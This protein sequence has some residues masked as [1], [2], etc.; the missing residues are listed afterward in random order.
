MITKFSRVEKFGGELNLP[1]DKSISHRSVMFSSLAKGKSRIVNY[2]DSEDINSTISIFRTLGVDIRKSPEEIIIEGLG[3]KGLKKSSTNLDAGNSGTTSRLVCGILCAQ[4]FDST[5]IGDESLSKRPMNR[6]MD[7]LG[8]FG[9]KFS[10]NNGY[11]PLT[12]H[13]VEN[14]TPVNYELK[15]ASAQV[16]SAMLLAGMHLKEKSCIIEKEI[17]RDHTERMLGMPFEIKDGKKYIYTSLDYYPEA[18]E[19]YVPSDISTAAFFIVLGMCKKDSDIILKNVSLNETRAG[20]VDVASKM[21]G[22]IEV[23]ERKEIGS[24][25]FGD[26]RIRF[27]DLKNIKIP[28]EIIPNIIDEIPVLS[29]A[30]YFAE[31]KF[32]IRNAEELRVKECDR[33]KAMVENYKL[34]GLEVEEFADGF[35]I[36]G[37]IKNKEVVFDSYGD[38]RIAMAFAVMI[39]LTGIDSGVKDFDCV[40][41]SNPGFLQQVAKITR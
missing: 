12:V 22:R 28:K 41:I 4:D 39:L 1:G 24:E 18:R 20:I 25:P 17:T 21:N 14:L 9:A 34:L 31:G 30:G 29:V 5:L 6:V 33:I 10:S 11:L 36:S 13:S 35:S 15:V 16:K 23:I 40:K 8:E 37:E 32:E 2:L 26:I 38:H 7:P 19:Y 27:S 3:Y